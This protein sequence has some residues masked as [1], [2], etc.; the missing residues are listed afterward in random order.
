MKYI[1]HLSLIFILFLKIAHSVETTD[2]ASPTRYIY[3]IVPGQGDFG[4]TESDGKLPKTIPARYTEIVRL[5]TPSE[6][7]GS[8]TM[9]ILASKSA[10][11]SFTKSLMIFLSNPIL[12]S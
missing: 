7:T 5:E 6:P 10:K 11:H 9:M 3:I 1:F 2:G 4:G 12:N 8:L